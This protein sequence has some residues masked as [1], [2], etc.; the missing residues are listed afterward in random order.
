MRMNDWSGALAAAL[1]VTAMAACTH[2][3]VT[4]VQEAPA[5]LKVP[6]DQALAISARGTGVQIYEC[7]PSATDSSAYA[8]TL[9]APEAQLRY[10]AG[11]PLGKHYAGPTWEANDGSKVVG[12]V[13]AKDD[14]ADAAAIPLLLLRAKQTS[15]TGVFGNVRFVQRLHTVGGKAPTTG[16]DKTYA[17]TQVRVAYTADYYFYTTKP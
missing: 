17:E 5:A 15:G 6:N 14:G 13:I 1:V 9:K 4:L 7:K 8:W 2:Q 11:K 3:H 16:C 10:E 12:E